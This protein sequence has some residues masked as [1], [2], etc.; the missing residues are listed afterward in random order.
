MDNVTSLQD[1]LTWFDKHQPNDPDLHLFLRGQRDRYW[2]CVPSIAREPPFTE[3]AIFDGRKQDRLQA[4]WILFTRFRDMT[5]TLEPS[6]V[7]ATGSV[8]SDWRR[9]ILARHHGLP[10]RLLDWTIKPFVALYFAVEGNANACGRG[11]CKLC[12][13]EN[14]KE[15]HD[16]AIFVLMGE[17]RNVFSISGLA[18]DNKHPPH[19]EQDSFGIFVPPDI[20]QRVTVQGSAFTISSNPREPVASKPAVL[21]PSKYRAKIRQDLS[22]IGVTH[23]T[24]FPDLDGVSTWLAHDCKTW[25]APYGIAK[26]RA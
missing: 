8:E 14:N 18:R 4:E 17:R 11:R 19:Y 25:G 13:G 10:T 5:A 7:A 6:W 22:R 20:D 21:I 23:A 9:L 1:F 24:L 16:S 3:N 26:S 12:G 15:H 2:K